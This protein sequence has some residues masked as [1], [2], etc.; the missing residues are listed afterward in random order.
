MFS[1]RKLRKKE[2]E[3]KGKDEIF[4]IFFQFFLIFDTSMGISNELT[5]LIEAHEIVTD[6]YYKL[7]DL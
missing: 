2:E 4:F 7:F 5:C 3:E 1:F 6:S